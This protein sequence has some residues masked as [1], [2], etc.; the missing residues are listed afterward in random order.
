MARFPSNPS[1]AALLGAALALACADPSS[2]TPD[3]TPSL[4]TASAR[5]G[6]P[7]LRVQHSGT[8]N[9]LQAISP[10]SSEVVW[11]SGVGGTF[12]VTIDGGR[13]WRAG[14]VD[15]ADGQHAV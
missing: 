10:V 1:A 12:V 11:A 4:E 9:R 14:V 6:A 8:T 3:S 2:P 15:G 5:A 13:H 7:T